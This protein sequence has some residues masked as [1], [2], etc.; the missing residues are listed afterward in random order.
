MNPPNFDSPFENLLALTADLRSPEGCPW[1]KEQTHLSVIPHLLEETYEVVDTIERGDDSHLK[2]ELG[3]LLFQITFHSQL[4]KERGAFGFQDVAN[5]V[6]QKLVF[7]HPHVY[8]NTEGIHSGDQV[9]AQW[10]KLKQKEKE[11]KGNIDSDKS[12]LAGI[13]KALPAIQRS[14]KIQSKVT[15]QGFD[16]PTVSGVFEK[17]QEEIKEL[18][19]ELQTKGSLSSKKLP[20][21]ERVEDE[22]G[23][24][25]FLLV[26]LS[27]K[28]SIDP[29]TCLRRANE[30]FETRFRIV[31]D[32]VSQT[33]KTLKDHSLEE[34]DLFWNQSK[35]Q[36]KDKVSNHKKSDGDVTN[37]S[38]Q[39]QNR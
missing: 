4:A 34:L 35:L 29:E 39:N 18:D 33:G 19:V 23:D 24:L 25:F 28:L 37:L 22:L 13:P 2:E 20:Y 11:K 16:W 27:R 15:K 21:D 9:L 31:E 17:F 10:D 7:R 12:I 30:K 14:E 26:N 32:L 38:D 3:D 5:D 6:F 36:L 1:D 8:G